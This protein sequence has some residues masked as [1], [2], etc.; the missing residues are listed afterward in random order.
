MMKNLWLRLKR[1][2]LFRLFFSRGLRGHVF[3]ETFAN[4]PNSH[5]KQALTFMLRREQGW[6]M[7]V[8][9]SDIWTRQSQFG[10]HR[11][12]NNITGVCHDQAPPPFQGGLLADEM[13][14]AKTLS[15]ICLITANQ[16]GSDLTPLPQSP[17]SLRSGRQINVKSTLLVVPPPRKLHHRSKR[18]RS[19]PDYLSSHITLAKTTSAVGFPSPKPS[20]CSLVNACV[21]KG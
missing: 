11:Y 6:A 12:Q 2:L 10:I 14:L 9:T 20:Y 18:S 19:Y 7:G 16:M 21:R 17:N 5:Q 8:G 4:S 13:G 15:M 1:R 3:R